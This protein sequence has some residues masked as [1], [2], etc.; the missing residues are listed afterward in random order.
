MYLRWRASTRSDGRNVRLATKGRS[1][2]RKLPADVARIWL[3]TFLQ[4]LE[5]ADERGYRSGTR[6]RKRSVL[7]EDMNR[8]YPRKAVCCPGVSEDL[9]RSDKSDFGAR[10]V[11]TLATLP[12]SCSP[13][14]LPP[15]PTRSAGQPASYSGGP[16]LKHECFSPIHLSISVNRL[17]M[18]RPP[19]ERYHHLTFLAYLMSATT[20]NVHSQR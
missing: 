16:C 12:R 4:S 8:T 13:A 20:R 10:S 3:A 14:I 5:P 9:K 15:S 18:W 2:L 19:I 7:N 17:I 11:D 6:A 1:T